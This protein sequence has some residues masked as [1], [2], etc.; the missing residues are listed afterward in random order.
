M[1]LAGSKHNPL[2]RFAFAGA[3]VVFICALAPSVAQAAFGVSPP[4]VNT[5]ALVPGVTYQQTIYLVQDRPDTDLEIQTKLDIPDPAK[6]WITLDK[7]FSFVIPKGTRQFPVT[8]TIAV[9]KDAALNKYSGNLAFTTQPGKAGQVTIAL[10]VNVALNLVVGNNIVE[11]FSVPR[12]LFSDVEE[13]WNPRVIVKF[14]NDGNIPE[15]FESASFD[16]YDQYDTARLAYVTKQNDFPV[17][18][19]F[20][21]NEYTIEFPTNF[22][23]GVGDYWG[24]VVFYGKGQKVIASQKN[25]FHVLPAGSLSSWGKVTS[26]FSAYWLYYIAAAALIAFGVWRVRNKRKKGISA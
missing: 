5:D 1:N 17:T 3:F 9:P 22:H 16:L 25:I 18:P 12:V 19:A 21:T 20:S 15:S 8:V 14:E 4:F 13:G 24:N 7:G 26:S 2:Y 10:G 11:K 23:L 6:G